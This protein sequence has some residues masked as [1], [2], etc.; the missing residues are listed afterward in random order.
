[1]FNS[2]LAKALLS[3]PNA[4]SPKLDRFD[5][6]AEAEGGAIRVSSRPIYRGKRL[7]NKAPSRFALRD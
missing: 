2:K 1:M 4:N 6:E 5:L 7:M 3:N